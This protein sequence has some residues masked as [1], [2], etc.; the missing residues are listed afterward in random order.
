M[1]EVLARAGLNTL[2]GVGI[3]FLV[4][5][6]I[7]FVISAFVLINKA[8]SAMKNRKNKNTPAPAPVPK[9][10][11]VQAAAEEEI[12][13][14]DTELVAVIAAAIASYEGTTPEG[15]VVRSIRKVNTTWKR[16]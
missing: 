2:M 14:D 1:G 13:T 11:P 7:S 16:G 9:S 4:L 12:S 3:V 5:I 15:I 10:A 6:L 8:E